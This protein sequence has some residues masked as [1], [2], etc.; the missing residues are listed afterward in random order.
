MCD[1]RWWSTA[2]G[3]VLAEEWSDPVLQKAG[4]SIPR[5]AAAIHSRPFLSNMALWLLALLFQIFS[6]PQ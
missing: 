3:K 2:R 5:T 1:P 6:S 4:L